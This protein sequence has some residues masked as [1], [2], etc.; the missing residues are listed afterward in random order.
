MGS[1]EDRALRQHAQSLM[2]AG[3]ID[4]AEELLTQHISSRRNDHEAKAILAQV[5]T[6]HRDFQRAESLL[7][8]AIRGDRKRADYHAVLAELLTTAGRHREAVARFDHAIKLH[9]GFD[10]AIAGKAEVYLRT[11]KPER[12]IEVLKNAADTPITAVP[13][14]RALIRLKQFDDA[15]ATAQRH[16]PA[17]DAPIDAQR[18]L[19]F[20][21]AQACERAERFDEA[22]DACSH[23][24]AISAHGWTSEADAQRNQL[25]METFSSEH[26]PTLPRADSPDDRPVFVVG[27]LRSGSTL[28]EQIIDAHPDAFGAGELETLPKLAMTMQERLGTRLPWPALLQETN[29]S[30]LEQIAA[31]YLSEI[32]PLA[33]QAKKI[34]DKQL[35]NFMHLGLI[36]LLFPKA[37]VIHCQRHPMDLGVSCWMQKLPPGTNPWA[38]SLEAIGATY[39][40]AESLMDH[41]KQVL[42]IPI[43]EVRYEHLVEDL[44]GQVRQILEFCDLEFDPICL[45][46]WETGR[47]VLTLSSDQVRKPIYASP[48][49]R[50]VAWGDHLTPLREALGEAI[51]RYE[52]PPKSAS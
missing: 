33:P 34:V 10:A 24:N 9:A 4:A 50:H 12:T 15:I 52:Q 48:V 14:T 3:H 2:Q 40:L 30:G 32:E 49:G 39:R 44:G 8:Q 7:M 18:G 37:R 22:T 25:L 35:G 20:A 19:W 16:L 23:G 28:V 6:M 51:E 36:A 21:L 38:A 13:R 46:F 17:T 29:E 26:L 1:Q 42:D 11:G 5:A 27:L 45:R 41:W 47:T 43:L 31:A